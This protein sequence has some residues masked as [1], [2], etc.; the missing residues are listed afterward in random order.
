MNMEDQGIMALGQGMQAPTA[1]PP[2]VDPAAEAAFEQARL[3]MD[4]K[5]VGDE[6]LSA[7]EQIDPA[8]VQEFKAALQSLQ[9]PP[10]IIDALGQMVDAIL[11]EP[12]NYQENRAELIREGVPEDFLPPEF[13]AMF[14]GALNMALDQMSSMQAPAP[15]IPQG[16]AAGGIAQLNPIASGIAQMGRNGDTMLAHITPAEMRMLRRRG[17]AGTINP[18]TGLPEFFLKSVVKAITKPF[19]SVGKAISGAFKSISSAVKKFVSSSVGRMVSTIALGFFLGPAAASFLGA[20][21]GTA[22]A[23]GISGFVGSF[24]S[25]ILAG[26]NLKTALKNGA[27]A[28]VTA[29]VAA[30]V[31]GAPLT[32]GTPE[33]GS[34]S[35]ALSGQ[36]TKA[37]EGIGSF[38]SGASPDAAGPVPTAQ[39]IAAQQVAPPG[40][41]GVA[42]V[43]YVPPGAEGMGAAGGYQVPTPDGLGAAG[44]YQVSTPGG[45]GAAG[46]AGP[47]SQSMFDQ[48]KGFYSDYLS[49]SRNVLSSEEIAAKA[50]RM[51][52]EQ[53]GLSYSDAIKLVQSEQP[54]MLSRYGPMAAVG[55]G[56][57]YLGGA[58]SPEPPEDLNIAPKQ[59]GFDLLRQQPD[60]YGT[61]PGGA[62]TTYG[63]VTSNPYD[64]RFRT[65]Q[66]QFGSPLQ[67]YQYGI[68][69]LSP[70]RYPA[71]GFAKGGIAGLARFRDGGKVQNY[72]RR[73]GQ[74]SGPGTE[75]SDSIPAMLSD[76]EFVMT[77]RAVRGAGNGSRREGAKRMYQM[78]HK[79]ER[80]S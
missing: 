49:P 71:V 54:G 35:E 55:L 14:F 79:L 65:A 74:I 26:D 25:S 33:Y 20:G 64:P 21:A 47:G 38:F 56:A 59:T 44:G 57:A 70:R 75:T 19:K 69:S 4:P 32:G 40:A 42:D 39:E 27:V 11:A 36:F 46:T 66:Y 61:Q 76:G 28:G 13:D 9:L 34:V 7:G 23:T 3:Q 73:N 43:G 58:F 22:L 1:Q 29:G 10:E 31:S 48:A 72:P 52:A 12:Q 80:M 53:P 15:M 17:G 2:A 60:I 6:L 24:G 62:Q 16:F 78:M 30:G 67:N 18:A 50:G 51:V 8:A 5:E 37:K 41:A 45:M 77:A 63:S 68:A